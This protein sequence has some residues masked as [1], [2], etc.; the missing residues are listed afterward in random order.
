MIRKPVIGLFL[1]NEVIVHL[2]MSN[3]V[4]FYRLNLYAAAARSA[5]V[6]LVLFSPDN[7]SFNPDTLSGVTFIHQR[8]RWETINMPLPDIL[9][10]RFVGHTPA[11]VEEA[12]SIRNELSRRG[13]IKINSRHY[14]DKLALFEILSL[15]PQI[16]SYLPPTKQFLNMPE[17]EELFD[18]YGKLYLK[19]ADGRRGKQVIRVSRSASGGYEYSYFNERLCSGR[20]AS[21]AELEGK[22]KAVTGAGKTIV[23]AAVPLIRVDDRLLDFRGE[24]QRNGQGKLEIVSVLAR[25]GQK[26]SPVSTHGSSDLFENFL[27]TR[28]NQPEDSIRFLKTEIEHLLY[29]VYDCIERAYGPFGEIAV[30]FGLDQQGLI[31]LFECNAKSMKVSLIKCADRATVFK[32]FLN[33]MQYAGH[34]YTCGRQQQI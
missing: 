19:A 8:R 26:H 32:A 22:I 25:L 17:L 4:R 16:S 10:D 34:L 18:Q 3:S 30:D 11:Q 14:F 1:D 9:Y 29:A 12:D 5:G 15:C 23:Q 31:W 7:I 13:V 21:P 20:T 33:P 24:M 27:R 28:L 6:T 2:T